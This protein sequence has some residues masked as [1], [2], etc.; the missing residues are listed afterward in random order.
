MAVRCNLQ[1]EA[2]Y[3]LSLYHPVCYVTCAEGE[4]G[5]NRQ[6]RVPQAGEISNDFPRNLKLVSNVSLLE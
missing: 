4:R 1:T 3:T 2:L 5:S 6:R